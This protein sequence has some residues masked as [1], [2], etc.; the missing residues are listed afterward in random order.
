MCTAWLPEGTAPTITMTVLVS[1]DGG[2][3]AAAYPNSVAAAASTKAAKGHTV[4]RS[5]GTGASL[6]SLSAM[7]TTSRDTRTALTG[8]GIPVGNPWVSDLRRSL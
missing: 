7:G 6:P 8:H 2:L 1:Q 5:S 4:S 3:E